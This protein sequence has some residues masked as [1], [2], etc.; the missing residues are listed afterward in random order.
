[1]KDTWHNRSSQEKNLGIFYVH[2]VSINQKCDEL[3][4]LLWIG[5]ICRSTEQKPDGQGRWLH[6]SSV[7]ARSHEEDGTHFCHT[8]EGTDKTKPAY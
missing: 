7:T 8:M 2:K 1:M 3:P 4:Y 6:L 5:S